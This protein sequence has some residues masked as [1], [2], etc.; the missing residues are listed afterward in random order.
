MSSAPGSIVLLESQDSCGLIRIEWQAPIY[1]SGGHLV[2]RI[3][4]R[5]TKFK[6]VSVKKLNLLAYITGKYRVVAH[7][8]S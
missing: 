5:E 8:D 3:L 1:L 7:R 4:W 6:V 2:V